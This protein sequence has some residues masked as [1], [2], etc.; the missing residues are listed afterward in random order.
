MLVSRNGNDMVK[1]TSANLCK[2]SPPPCRLLF[3]ICK[4][5]IISVLQPLSVSVLNTFMLFL[6][7]SFHYAF[8]L[9]NNFVA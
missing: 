8:I 1:T 2:V 3:N 6:N 9:L 7:R 5:Q 4:L